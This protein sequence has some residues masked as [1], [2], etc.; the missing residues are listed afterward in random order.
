MEH[1]RGGWGV[2]EG[3]SKTAFCKEKVVT[4]ILMVL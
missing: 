2:G 1:T 4:V 3:V